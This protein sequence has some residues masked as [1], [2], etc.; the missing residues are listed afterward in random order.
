MEEEASVSFGDRDRGLRIEIGGGV[1]QGAGWQR[2]VKNCPSPH[3]TSRTCFSIPDDQYIVDTI[4]I[5]FEAAEPIDIPWLYS[6]HA[7]C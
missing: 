2:T 3:P 5:W 6:L 1:S 4:C 7:G